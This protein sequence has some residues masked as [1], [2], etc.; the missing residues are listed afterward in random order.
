[1]HRRL[2]DIGVASSAAGGGVGWGGLSRVPPALVEPTGER[3][4]EFCC[5]DIVVTRGRRPLNHPSLLGSIHKVA[6]RWGLVGRPMRRPTMMTDCKVICAT[7]R[8]RGSTPF[9]FLFTKVIVMVGAVVTPRWLRSEV[10]R[11]TP[12]LSLA[13]ARQGSHD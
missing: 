4:C 10:T 1:M 3:R 12:S 6:S 11:R 13:S 5:C 9:L 8:R 7:G 2:L